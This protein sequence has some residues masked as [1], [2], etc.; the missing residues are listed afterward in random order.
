MHKK[1]RNVVY[2]FGGVLIDW[3]PYYLYREFFGEDP[4]KTEN[5]L[6]EIGF[7]QLNQRFDAG[8]KFEILAREVALKFPHYEQLY[9]HFNEQFPKTLKVLDESIELLTELHTKGIP[10]YGLTNWASET[11]HRVK[12]DYPFL[13]YLKGIVVSGDEGLIKPD[14]KIYLLALSR[15]NLVPTETLFIDDKLANV[16]AAASVGMHAH[17]F[18]STAKLRIALNKFGLI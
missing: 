14:P 12:S 18:T 2:D 4:K 17:H 13:N 15:F 1:V 7:H 8:E 9:R 16:Q 11:F 6:T 5:F 10:L 3:N